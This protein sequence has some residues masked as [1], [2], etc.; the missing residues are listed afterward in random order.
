M[1]SGFGTV[2]GLGLLIFL[3]IIFI[4]IKSGWFKDWFKLQDN[5]RNTSAFTQYDFS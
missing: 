4:G 1:G 2:V 3:V 5:Y